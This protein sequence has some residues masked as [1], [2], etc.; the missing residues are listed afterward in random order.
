M[1]NKRKIMT[2]QE[3]IEEIFKEIVELLKLANNTK[4]SYNE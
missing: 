3:Q 1:I 4:E 2:T